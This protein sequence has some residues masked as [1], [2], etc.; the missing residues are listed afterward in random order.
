M[1][2]GIGVNHQFELCECLAGVYVCDAN[3]HRHMCVLTRSRGRIPRQ[4]EVLV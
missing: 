3:T 2:K 1:Q 4:R